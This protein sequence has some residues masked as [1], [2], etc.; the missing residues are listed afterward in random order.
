M[1][2]FRNSK[3]ADEAEKIGIPVGIAETVIG[4]AAIGLARG[5]LAKIAGCLL[6]TLGACTWLA[7][8][9]AEAE[10]RHLVNEELERRAK[11]VFKEMCKSTEEES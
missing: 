8:G 2:E 11:K 6:V 10:R 5:V 4:V 1:F 7:L 9:A 3:E